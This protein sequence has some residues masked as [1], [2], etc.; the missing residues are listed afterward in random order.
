[1]MLCDAEQWHS[2]FHSLFHSKLDVH[3]QMNHMFALI[4][5]VKH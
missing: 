4:S 1:M 5:L 2:E 3:A